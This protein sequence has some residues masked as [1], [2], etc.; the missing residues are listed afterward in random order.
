MRV[1]VAGA[2]GALGTQLVCHLLAESHEVI[3]FTRSAVH[4]QKSFASWAHPGRSP[5]TLK[6][7]PAFAPPGAHASGGVRSRPYSDSQTW[8]VACF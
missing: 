1:F 3:G 4:M 2:G 8:A 7:H 6:I 5:V